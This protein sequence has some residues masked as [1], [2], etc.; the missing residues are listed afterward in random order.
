[1]IQLVAETKCRRLQA[2]TTHSEIEA[3]VST[4]KNRLALNNFKLRLVKS[5]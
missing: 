4:R 3:F 5:G 1:M 2:Y